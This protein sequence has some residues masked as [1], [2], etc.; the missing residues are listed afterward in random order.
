MDSRHKSGPTTTIL[1]FLFRDSLVLKTSPNLLPFLV[2]TSV[3]H[4]TGPHSVWVACLTHL[5][6]MSSV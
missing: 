3:F 1:G 5:L 4:C 6:I 2:S